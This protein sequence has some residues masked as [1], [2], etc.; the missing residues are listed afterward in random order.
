MLLEKLFLTPTSKPLG[1]DRKSEE[2]QL[3]YIIK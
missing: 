1:A 2:S 3:K